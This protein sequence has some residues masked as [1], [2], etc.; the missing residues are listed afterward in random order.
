MPGIDSS[1][2][3]PWKIDPRPVHLPPVAGHDK[4]EESMEQ[5]GRSGLLINVRKPPALLVRTKKARPFF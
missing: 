3:P 4:M 5:E 1:L 2:C